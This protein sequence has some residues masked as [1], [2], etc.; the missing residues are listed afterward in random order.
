MSKPNLLY[1]VFLDANILFSA[2][3]REGAGLTKLWRLRRVHLL[4]SLYAVQE[5]KNNLEETDQQTRL[6]QL[7]E[8]VEVLKSS[9]IRAMPPGIWLPEKDW[10]ILSGAIESKANF[11]LTGDGK[12]FGTYFGKTVDGVRVER[13]A[14]FLRIVS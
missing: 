1:R 5:A 6:D 10:P 8:T 12:H 11:L 14:D 13:P 7:L 4:T 9:S 3:Y 2:A